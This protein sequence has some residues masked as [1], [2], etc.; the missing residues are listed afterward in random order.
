M[1]LSVSPPTRLITFLYYRNLPAAVAFYEET[2]GF[3]L[4][5]DQGW[6]KIY[7]AA[8]GAYLGLVDE[9]R[10]FHRANT[11]KPVL[12]TLGVADVDAWYAHIQAQGVPILR[13]IRTSAE[14]HIRAFVCEDPEGY[15]VEIQTFLLDSSPAM[16]EKS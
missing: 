16:V 9:T 13:P 4:A 2:M 14:L 5:V 10:G 11:I 15:A 7:H 1:P 8:E 6:S 12:V 3:T